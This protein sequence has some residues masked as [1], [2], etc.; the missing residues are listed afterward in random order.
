MKLGVWYW[1]Q[2]TESCTLPQLSG[3]EDSQMLLRLILVTLVVLVGS[4]GV[5]V[6][7]A[8]AEWKAVGSAHDG[9]DEWYI[10]SDTAL[11]HGS[12]V[13]MSVLNDVKIKKRFMGYYY[14]S[15]KARMTFNCETGS[16]LVLTSRYYPENMA[17]GQ[18]LGT[19][20][21]DAWGSGMPESIGQ[22]L[23]KAACSKK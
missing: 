12:I 11:R 14:L 1:P 22:V 21:N 15:A 17:R 18:V 16:S 13:E 9:N 3:R 5:S 20:T 2:A 8:H 7:T 19:Y 23:W 6:L 10:D 4:T